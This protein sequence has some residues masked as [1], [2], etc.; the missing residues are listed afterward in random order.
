[1]LLFLKKDIRLSR[2]RDYL[3]LIM[4]GVVLAVHWS[5]FFQSIQVSTV[6]V[7]LLTFSTFPV[8]VTFLEPL[9]LREKLE[10][11]DLIMALI[12]FTGVAMILPDYKT[13]ASVSQG[14][15]WGLLSG[16]TY[17]ILSI[18]NRSFVKRYSGAVIAF[19]EQGAAFI[20]MLPLLFFESPVFNIEQILLLAMLGIIFTGVSHTLFISSLKTVKTQKAGIISC[21]EPVYGIIF[22]ALLIGEMPGIRE[23]IGGAI[24]L[25]TA[26]Y[27]T[28]KNI[29]VQRSQ[30]DIKP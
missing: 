18:L 4:C 13:G 27:S 19:Y 9:F 21:L 16:F 5:T 29:D 1:M 24:I 28:L 3:Y 11:K 17:S 15:I 2:K 20:I 23:F 25:G 7:G 12:T 10:I 8:F 14:V 26:F 22:S 30:S 6:A